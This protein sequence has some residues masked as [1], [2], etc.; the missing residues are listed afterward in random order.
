MANVVQILF[1]SKGAKKVKGEVDGLN[2]STQ[3]LTASALKYTAV[4]AI[5][6][7]LAKKSIDA[8]GFQEQQEK[9]LEVA[10]GG[11]NK[12]LL[13][14][15]SALQQ[16]TTFGDE[17]IIGVQASIAAFTDS[18][19]QIKGATVATLDFATAMGFDLKSAGELVAKTLG[20]TTNALTRYGVN[21][22]G[23]VGST[24]RL[25][26]LTE[27]I[28]RLWGGQAT[29]AAQTMTGSMQQASNA[30]GDLAEEFGEILAPAINSAT[31]AIK[32]W[33]E[34]L[35][36]LGADDT[37]Q[38]TIDELTKKLDKLE[39][40]AGEQTW[41]TVLFSGSEKAKEEIEKLRVELERLLDL[42]KELTSGSSGSSDEMAAS[43]RLAAIE[44]EGF[45]LALREL[46]LP[47][48]GVEN[49]FNT[50]ANDAVNIMDQFA[51][52]LSQAAVYGQDMGE[53]VVS[54]LK[55]IAS[56]FITNALVYAGVALLMGNPITAAGLAVGAVTG[57]V[58][59]SAAPQPIAPTPQGLGRSTVNVTILGD[60]IGSDDFVENNLIPSINRAVSQGRA[61]LA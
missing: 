4:A 3:S 39:T 14:Q 33:A 52:S 2:R 10:L 61:A 37:L 31:I 35:S 13:E 43:L 27:G 45:S 18:E 8:F 26:T 40:G 21:V 20:S 38:N 17:A 15:A 9:K 28:A 55:A 54:S 53:A 56:Q 5:V 44:A 51:N 7:G 36:E 42:Q 24:E 12:A 30:V 47:V 48:V 34:A 25:T 59:G 16:L 22:T 11:V 46:M 19:E 49:D 6:V 57:N 23:V 50:W 58:L 60:V 1:N 29:A 32:G 41:M